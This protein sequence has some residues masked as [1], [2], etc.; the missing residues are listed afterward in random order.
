MGIELWMV[1]NGAWTGVWCEVG[2]IEYLHDGLAVAVR[3]RTV[4]ARAKHC[5]G[6][7]VLFF[8]TRDLAC[9]RPLLFFLNQDHQLKSSPAGH[10]LYLVGDSDA[11]VEIDS[12]PLLKPSSRG[13]LRGGS[14]DMATTYKMGHLDHYI[15]NV[16]L[17]CFQFSS[18]ISAMMINL[19]IGNRTTS[20]AAGHRER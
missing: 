5:T 15:V 20:A 9:K 1:N 10:M 4:A 12:T 18:T 13:P 6:P 16:C 14:Q 8:T 19:E 17:F 2:L 3:R 11:C 7:G